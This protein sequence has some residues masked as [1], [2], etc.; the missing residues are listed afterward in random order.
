MPPL[1]PLDE[2][3]ES[4]AEE[5]DEDTIGPTDNVVEPEKTAPDANSDE[6]DY[7]PMGANKRP[8]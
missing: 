5:R 4:N 7:N 6:M 2:I 3:T 8:K 1:Q